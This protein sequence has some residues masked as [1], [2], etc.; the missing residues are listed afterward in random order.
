MGARV[1]NMISLLA[2]GGAALDQL[3]CVTGPAFTV[4]YEPCGTR[5]GTVGGYT[6]I[7]KPATVAA[8]DNQQR[9]D[10]TVWG[11]ILT[12]VASRKGLGGTVIHCECRDAPPDTGYLPTPTPSLGCLH[13]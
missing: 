1:G 3:F 11:D 2:A 10:A 9:M 5:G 7:W 6:T 4:W 8:L 12:I 13:G